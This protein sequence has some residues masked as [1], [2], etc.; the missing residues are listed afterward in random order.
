MTSFQPVSTNEQIQC[1]AIL[2]NNIWY[3]HYVS[4]IGIDQVKY[5]VEKFQSEN[6]ISEQLK[7]GYLYYLIQNN[8]ENIGYLSIKKRASSLFLSKIYLSKSHRSKGIG[9]SSMEY[10]EKQARNLKCSSISLT[11]NKNNINS[12]KSYKKIGFISLGP[13][14]I[15]IG[16]GFIM[17]DYKMEKV[18]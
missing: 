17:D 3:E 2:A 5:M 11:V 9:R 18:L 10:I 6:A 1:V 13:I 7:D 14:V 12:I 8:Q 15:D 16:N 4:I